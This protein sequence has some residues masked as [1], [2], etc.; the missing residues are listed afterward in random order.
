MKDAQT[1]TDRCDYQQ[2]KAKMLKEQ[3]LK[4]Q[5]AQ[6]EANAALAEKKALLAGHTSDSQQT[7]KQE[8]M[9]LVNDG[10]SG[11]KAQSKVQNTPEYPMAGY[12]SQ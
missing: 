1:Q 12:Q 7:R 4:A 11:R 6:Q 10:K 9:N 3:A 5:K 8:W 2:I